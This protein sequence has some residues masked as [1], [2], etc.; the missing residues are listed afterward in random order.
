MAARIKWDMSK[1]EA[2]SLHY[3]PTGTQALRPNPTPAPLKQPTDLE[4]HSLSR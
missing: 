1:Q 4:E 3:K 2:N